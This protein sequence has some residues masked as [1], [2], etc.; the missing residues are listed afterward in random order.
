MW[1]ITY[2][3]LY[4]NLYIYIYVNPNL[5]RN[6]TVRLPHPLSRDSQ[7]HETFLAPSGDKQTCNSHSAQTVIAI[8][9]RISIV[10]KP[11]FIFKL[12]GMK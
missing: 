10:F 6:I 1:W 12:L 5:R 7:G 4:V 11:I 8:Q 3:H 2:D 9:G